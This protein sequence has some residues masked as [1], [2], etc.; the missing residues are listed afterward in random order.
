MKYDN[1]RS[2]LAIWVS[3]LAAIIGVFGGVPGI[4][5]LFFFK[6]AVIVH[7]FMPLIVFDP[8][9]DKNSKY[10]KFSLKGLAKISNPNEND[11]IIREMKLYGKSQDSSG[12]YK[13]PGNKPIIYN[14]NIVGV[15]EPKEV[16]K[17]F[18]YAYLIFNFSHFD[19]NQEPGIMLSPLIAEGSEE[20]G[21]PIF[22]IFTPSFNQL[23][24]YNEKRI[25]LSLVKEVSRGDLC[26]AVIFNNE[27]IKI[28]P[29][30]IIPLENFSYYVQ[31]DAIN[32]FNKLNEMKNYKTK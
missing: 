19:N 20:L 29:K 12:K 32:I 30:D 13:F 5:K 21:H 18:G 2:S 22:H 3:I 14:L 17:A 15:A 10:P 9:Y 27:L 8:G 25:P 16:I 11:I 28:E 6:P 24:E 1:F 4:N 31:E 23:F 7:G 26:F